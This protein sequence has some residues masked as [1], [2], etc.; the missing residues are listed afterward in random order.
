MKTSGKKEE[1]KFNNENERILDKLRRRIINRPGKK[2][3]FK[4]I[5]EA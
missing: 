1:K 4:E 2:S 5:V 3:R